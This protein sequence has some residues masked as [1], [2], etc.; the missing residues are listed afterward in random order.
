MHRLE[1]LVA[2]DSPGGD[3]VDYGS[4]TEQQEA[5]DLAGRGHGLGAVV[6]DGHEALVLQVRDARHVDGL[7][8]DDAVTG[9][10]SGARLDGNPAALDLVD[11]DVAGGVGSL[12]F[13]VLGFREFRV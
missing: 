8:R 9:L 1:V 11:E 10:N 6:G 3:A 4:G 7:G 2:E 12:G 5:R 13:R